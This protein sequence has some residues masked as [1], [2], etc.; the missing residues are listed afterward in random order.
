[1]CQCER[2]GTSVSQSRDMLDLVW[3]VSRNLACN[4]SFTQ[5][6]VAT[7]PTPTVASRYS[8]PIRVGFMPA[9]ACQICCSQKRKEK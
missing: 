4:C 5:S 9:A 7:R 2:L 3:R 6:F 1:M 8:P